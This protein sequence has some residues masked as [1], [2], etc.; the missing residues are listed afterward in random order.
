MERVD[1]LW[2]GFERLRNGE[3]ISNAAAACKLNRAKR[4]KQPDRDP[5]P[6]P[7]PIQPEPSDCTTSGRVPERA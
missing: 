5:D 3:E 6:A 2:I 7:A 4:E 1:P